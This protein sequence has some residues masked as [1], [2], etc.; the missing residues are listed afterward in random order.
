MGFGLK[1]FSGIPLVSN[2]LDPDQAQC[3]FGK[4]LTKY[5]VRQ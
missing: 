5:V 1:R 2:R 3:L 4:L